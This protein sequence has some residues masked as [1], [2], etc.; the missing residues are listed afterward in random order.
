MVTDDGWKLVGCK[1]NKENCEAIGIFLE[2]LSE[3]RDCT[4]YNFTTK[5]KYALSVSHKVNDRFVSAVVLE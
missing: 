3:E 5:L 1:M 4:K 2:S